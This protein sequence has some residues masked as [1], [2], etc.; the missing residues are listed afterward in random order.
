MAILPTN[1]LWRLNH[2]Y[3][4]V[5]DDGKV[6]PFRLNDAQINMANSLWSR[7]I[8]LKARQLGFTTF[9]DLFILDECLFRDTVEGGIIC[10]NMDNAK[11][12]FRRKIQFPYQHMSGAIVGL[13]SALTESKTE[14]EFANG[15]V[16]SVGTSLRSG[17][18]QYLHVSEFG[19]IAQKYP[20]KAQEIVTGALET[21]A[22][23]QMVFIE[24]TAA[25][26]YG[27]FYDYCLRAKTLADAG[28]ELTPLDYRF[29]FF[30]WFLKPG[31]RLDTPVPLTPG[32]VDYFAQ[33]EDRIGHHLTL[34]QRN[35]YAKKHEALGEDIKQEHPS[36]PEEAFETS[37]QGAY[38]SEELA[39]MRKK[40]RICNVPVDES[41]LVDTWWDLGMNDAMSIWF[42]QDVDREIHAIDYYE[43]SGKGLAHYARVLTDK[44]YHYGSHYA[45]HDIRVR[46]LAGEGKSRL[47]SALAL[48]IRFNVVN[49][50]Q[51][52]ADSIQAARNIF[53]ILWLD[54]RYCAAGLVHLEAYRKRW[55]ER[56][57]CYDDTPLHDEHS[58]GADAFQTLGLGHSWGRS[59]LQTARPVEPVPMSQMYMM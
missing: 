45:P 59:Y 17:T 2:L 51:T 53:P 58:N 3:T 38:F 18:Y 46:E 20:D 47:E 28:A 42:T 41:T 33:L 48:G 21:V 16:I 19:R 8:I 12:I 1:K 35:W 31:N 40:G 49:R 44:G 15:S 27:Y 50:P 24:S 25:G 34:A 43:D 22:P 57:S 10:D 6:V 23:G 5:T 39:A 29:H 26:R 9:I 55:N 30:P 36:T 56:L 54:Q 32:L 52:K 37:I 11:K 13:R 14:M 7:N 4:I